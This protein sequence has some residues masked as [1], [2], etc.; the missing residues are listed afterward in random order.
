MNTYNFK[1]TKNQRLHIGKRRPQWPARRKIRSFTRRLS[2]LFCSPIFLSALNPSASRTHFQHDGNGPQKE[3]ASFFACPLLSLLP[4]SLSKTFFCA[5]GIYAAVRMPFYTS[6]LNGRVI[7]ACTVTRRVDTTQEPLQQVPLQQ[8]Q[9]ETATLVTSGRDS[10]FTLT[11]SA[12]KRKLS[13]S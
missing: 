2:R 4:V 12:R 13:Q 10:T 9:P 11:W 3:R 8:E 1:N 7:A 5:G 6:V